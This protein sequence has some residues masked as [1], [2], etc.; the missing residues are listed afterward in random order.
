M[1]VRSMDFGNTVGLCPLFSLK[2]ILAFAF[3]IEAHA[4]DLKWLNHCRNQA[5]SL[6]TPVSSILLVFWPFFAMGELV[7]GLKLGLSWA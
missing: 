7:F 5:T 4:N 6:R 1:N 3:R 2:P